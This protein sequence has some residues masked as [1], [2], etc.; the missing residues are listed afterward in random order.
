MQ[1]MKKRIKDYWEGEAEIY[2]SSIEREL[3]SPTA[4]VWKDII[5]NYAPKREGL[6][7]LDIGTG[8]G[9]FPIILSDSGW[10][11][12]G[13]DITENMIKTAVANAKAHQVEA[14]LRVMDSHALTFSE[15]TFD[16][17]IC[18]NLT[19]TLENPVQAYQE[20]HRVLKPGGRLLV[21]DA[22]WNLHYFDEELHKQY[23]E[24]DAR[25]RKLYGRGT[26]A[27]AN[28]QEGE[29]I[30]KNL[31]MSDKKRPEWDMNMLLEIGFTKVFSE[32]NIADLIWGEREYD[33]NKTTP[34]FMVG[35]E[36]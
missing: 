2:N 33:L 22:N 30:S 29:E 3:L 23:M 5:H 17:V 19:W 21:F 16:L 28:T 13:I 31:F 24:N 27:H 7:V 35:A 32:R 26:H 12:T 36:K 14:D 4:K 18:R 1:T 10:Q 25:V 11:V 20:W 15:N 6:A 8:P 9:F 34:P